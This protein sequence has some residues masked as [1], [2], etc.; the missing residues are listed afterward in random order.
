MWWH[1]WKRREGDMLRITFETL[2]NMVTLYISPVTDCT[3]IM[4]PQNVF[5]EL[6][7]EILGDLSHNVS[8]RTF[9]YARPLKIQFCLRILAFWSKS[10]LGA[11]G[12]AKEEKNHHA[13]MNTQKRLHGCADRS[14]SSVGVYVW[15]LIGRTCKKV[16]F[17]T[18]Q[19]NFVNSFIHDLFL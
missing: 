5:L 10:S 4:H 16:W 11:F 18:L 19:L 9:G 6:K 17:F 13:D 7:T 1:P 8:K 14:E 15:A 2:V 12:I 3:Y